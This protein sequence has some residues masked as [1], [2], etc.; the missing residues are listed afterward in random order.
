MGLAT[1]RYSKGVTGAFEEEKRHLLGLV[2][3]KIPWIDAD[4][5]RKEHIRFNYIRRAMQVLLD[6]SSPNDGFKCVGDGALNDFQILGD[7]VEPYGGGRIWVGGLPLLLIPDIRY[8]NAGA[9]EGERSIHAKV[10]A[11]GATFIEDSSANFLANELVGRVVVPDITTPGTSFAIVSN[12]AT[13]ITVA[14]N[15]LTSGIVVGNRY[16]VNLSTPP[17]GP[18][19]TDGVY[20]NSYLD[21]VDG[22]EDP[23]IMHNIG[24][25]LEA[26]RFLQVIQTCFVRQDVT[27]LGEPPATYLD[28]DGNTH[29]V[30]KIAE[31][32]RPATVASIAALDV[33]DL[34][35]TSGDLTSFVRKIG[36][37]MTGNLTMAALANI[38]LAVGSTVDGRDV[39]VDGTKLDSITFTG[40]G[41]SALLNTQ[42]KGIQGSDLNG[43]T[44][45]SRNVSDDFRAKVA[46]GGEGVAGVVTDP[47]N[48]LVKLRTKLDRDDILDAAG[49][50]VYGRLTGPNELALAGTLTFSNASNSVLGVGTTFL[51]Q[52]QVGD[53]I[54]R[55]DDGTYITVASVLTNTS[56]TTVQAWPGT[57]GAFTGTRRRYTLSFFSRS[58]A[59]ADPAYTFALATDII[60]AYLESF[61]LYLLPTFPDDW[62]FPSDQLAGDIPLATTAQAGKVVL[63]PDLDTSATK[64]VTGADSRV[65]FPIQGQGVAGRFEKVR[66]GANVVLADVGGQLEI[67]VPSGADGADGDQGP[68]GPGF[69]QFT[70]YIS[71]TV[72]NGPGVFSFTHDFGYSV[73]AAWT[74]FNYIHERGSGF[75]AADTIKITLVSKP[76]A[77]S[78][79]VDF[80]VTTSG[81]GGDVDVGV[82]IGAAGGP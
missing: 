8:V 21:E 12:T 29:Y 32:V 41:I 62:I 61:P 46:G 33:T 14:G 74:A 82:Y 51:T 9:N 24:A 72:E 6:S 20:L 30:L 60:W 35:K 64:A 81:S 47:P 28:S 27:G 73:R 55:D 68:P 67:G 42:A 19:R 34:R 75:N 11:V 44:G 36:D 59:G 18:A 76:T 56:L 5:N 15:P 52:L 77:T 53:I 22:V 37:T 80:E 54:T 63:A 23:T 49:N 66:A 48:N 2:Q 1:G 50:K 58:E 71:S 7:A 16:R 69:T 78:V 3:R 26:Q 38:V 43:T 40:A 10:T 17:A 39:S 45:S 25:P 79:K 57:T 4:E 65:N 31:I 70:P 13:R